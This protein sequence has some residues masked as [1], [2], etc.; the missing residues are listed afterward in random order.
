VGDL[1]GLLAKHRFTPLMKR[2]RGSRIS[3]ETSDEN[4]QPI[5]DR[6]KRRR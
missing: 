6:P 2:A 3:D 4:T 1:A 5:A